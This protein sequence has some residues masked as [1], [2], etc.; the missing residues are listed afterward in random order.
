MILGIHSTHT[1]GYKYSMTLPVGLKCHQQYCT[2]CDG[3]V[4]GHSVCIYNAQN[5]CT[6]CGTP[7]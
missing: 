3:F 7:K 6:L 4:P 2:V 5:I 1:W